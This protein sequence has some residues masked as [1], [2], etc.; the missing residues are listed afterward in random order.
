MPQEK[1]NSPADTENLPVL[2]IS[3]HFDS[4]GLFQNHEIISKISQSIFNGNSIKTLGTLQ[5]HTTLM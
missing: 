3:E 2:F 4:F 5:E 1:K